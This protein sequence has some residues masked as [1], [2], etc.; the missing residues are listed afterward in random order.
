MTAPFGKFFLPGPTEVA[1]EV[2]RAQAQPMIGHRGA[3]TEALLGRLEAPLKAAFRTTNPV[4]IAAASAT[5]LMEAAIRNGVRRKVLCLVN[6]AFSERF[7]KIAAAC[8]KEVVKAEVPFGEAFEATRVRDL[9]DGSGA[10]AVTL[11][12]SETSTGVLNP[13]ADIAEVVRGTPDVLL[14]VDA[15][16]SL[17]GSPVETDAWDLD[18]VLTGSQKALAL[19]PGLALGVASPRMMERARSV[20]DRGIYFDL[21][22][23]DES[24]RK[25]QTPYTP[26]LSLLYALEAQLDRITAEGG[27][28]ARWAR[29]A[30]MRERVERWIAA[31][32]GG[33]L[34][35]SY[36]PPAGRRS[37]TVSCLRLP[38]GGKLVGGAVAKAMEARG[39]IIGAGYGKLKDATIRI[40]HMGDHTVAELES[41]LG[42]LEEVIKSA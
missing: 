8:G 37:W 13:V 22:A 9:L 11:A 27:I 21:V 6:G 29:H 1:P 30:A 34:G 18:F 31:E 15:V 26:A 17:A 7:A 38:E 5:G 25:R 2:L 24:F 4:L 16:T 14:L 32:A 20:P 39:Y 42:T 19:P 28:E 35:L 12:H 40:G 3:K 36:L 10:D 23:Y 41:L 33:K